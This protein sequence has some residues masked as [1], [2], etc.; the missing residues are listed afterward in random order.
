M[1]VWATKMQSFDSGRDEDGRLTMWGR[2]VGEWYVKALVGL[3]IGGVILL[4]AEFIILAVFTI[5][6]SFGF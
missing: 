2:P 4:G 3:V 5:T 1:T 6:H